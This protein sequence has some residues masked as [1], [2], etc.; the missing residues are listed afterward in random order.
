MSDHI[1]SMID[2]IANRDLVSAEVKF[3]NVMNDKVSDALSAEKERVA[4]TLF[5]DNESQDQ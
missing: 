5:K 3:Q 1:K 4:K 2:D